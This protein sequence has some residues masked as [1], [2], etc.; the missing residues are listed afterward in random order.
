M[1]MLFEGQRDAFAHIEKPQLLAC[2]SGEAAGK[3]G[4]FGFCSKAATD[5]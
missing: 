1:Q 3:D 5:C 2:W 4:E